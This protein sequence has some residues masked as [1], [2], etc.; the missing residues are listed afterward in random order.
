MAASALIYWLDEKMWTVQPIGT[1]VEPKKRYGDV[2]KSG[3]RVTAKFSGD[4]Y[5]GILLHVTSKHRQ[6][7]WFI[8]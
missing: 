7:F 8:F 3:E 4:P 1:I 5:P 6:L 2:F